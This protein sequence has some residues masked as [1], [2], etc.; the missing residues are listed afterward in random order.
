MNVFILQNLK[1]HTTS[2]KCH[3][4]N[5]SFFLKLLASIV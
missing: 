2:D 1:D 3:V 5:L 4:V